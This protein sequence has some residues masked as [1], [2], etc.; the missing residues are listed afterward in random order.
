MF[1]FSLIFLISVISAHAM[2]TTN[3]QIPEQQI[4]HLCDVISNLGA[5]K[6]ILQDNPAL[7]NFIDIPNTA[8]REPSPFYVACAWGQLAVVQFFLESNYIRN[9]NN[10]DAGMHGT[11]LHALV[12]G[13][14]AAEYQKKSPALINNYKT[15]L[16]LLCTQYH[17]NINQL[18]MRHDTPLHVAAN[19]GSVDLVQ[20]L[21]KLGADPTIVTTAPGLYPNY[22]AI[23]IAQRD[24]KYW[25]DSPSKQ[26]IRDEYDKKI[27]I[28]E[29]AVQTKRLAQ[30]VENLSLSSN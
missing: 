28:M 6:Q 25:G 17:A 18:G 20:E 16:H 12:Y 10:P 29:E 1:Y 5:V 15:I 21:V 19:R 27:A 14:A 30:N 13:I 7:C 22:T 11:A 4:S 8:K 2:E 23:E 3:L 9:I 26:A 24:K